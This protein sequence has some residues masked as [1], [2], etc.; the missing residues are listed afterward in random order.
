[1]EPI[2]IAYFIDRIIEG[3]TE[4]QLAEQINRLEN[5]GIEQILFCLYKSN[6][7]DRIPLK[8]RTEI[9][10]VRS[11][12]SLNTFKRMWDISRILRRE[13]IDIVQTYFFDSTVLGVICG[14]WAG[15]KKIISCRRD[16]GF[17]YTRKLLLILQLINKLTLRILVNSRAVKASVM[18]H[19]K[20]KPSKIDVI[21]NGIELNKYKFS[22]SFRNTSRALLSLDEDEICIG[23][24]ANM[25]R[26]VK[27]VDLF[28]EATRLLLSKGIK[29]KFYILGDGKFRQK[30]ER[31]SDTYG[32]NDHLVFLG[33]ADLKDN[34]LAAMDIGVITSD[35]EGLSNSIMEYMASNVLPV[36]SDVSGNRELVRSSQNGFLFQAGDA[37]DLARSLESASKNI[38]ER[39]EMTARG[40]EFIGRFDWS[41]KKT[42]ILGY[43]K[44]LLGCGR[45]F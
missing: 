37:V 45:G 16:L 17:W 11:L 25:S 7:H 5:N 29:A 32:L 2:R 38:E 22:V 3:G 9:I 30:L 6:E 33:K 12:L 35:S 20:V 34:L 44:R 36:V 4:L 10:D 39:N 42:E 21:N 8:C 31:L 23:I 27:R 24:I 13:E 1:M 43:Y 14:K 15:V 40:R 26:Q 28:V 41:L 18:M 19:E